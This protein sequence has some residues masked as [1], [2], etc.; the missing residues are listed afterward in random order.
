MRQGCICAALVILTGLPAVRADDTRNY[1]ERF[2]YDARTNQWVE[3]APPVPG[4]DGGDL[5]IARGHLAR[6]EFKKARKAFRQWF[7]FYPASPLMPEALFYAAETEIA[8]EEMKPRSGDLIGAYERL[9]EL[10]QGWPA[11]DL[12]D[13]ALRKEMLIAELI[14]F[15]GRKQRVWKIF[16]LSATE[17]ALQMLSRIADDFAKD[18]PIG[19]QALRLKA[20]YHFQQGEFEEAELT[21]ARI[22]RDYPRGR[23]AKIA[24]LRSGE[25]AIGRFR[26]VE[27]DEA[28]LLE[29]EVYFE[30]FE[31]R[32]P[33]DAEANRIPQRLIRVQE[34]RAEKDYL[35]GRYYERTR[36]IDAAAYYY[37]H[38][39]RTYP[40]TTWAAEARNRLIA[41][42]AL[43]LPAA[44]Q[45]PAASQPVAGM[46]Q[47][48]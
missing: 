9:Q 46:I 13:R 28:D 14:L 47:A 18:S 35:V 32:Y 16:W 25:S 4:T 8:A 21:Y 26:G 20:D 42:G 24:L 27:F 33:Q 3:L 7:K 12:H 11:H 45:D 39:D 44:E 19:E 30:D 36:K 31:R 15:K 48:D 43:E 2:E 5:A 37:R 29:A 23:Y 10:L 34:S 40:Q 22:I 6:R 41:L 1:Y 38:V 17:E